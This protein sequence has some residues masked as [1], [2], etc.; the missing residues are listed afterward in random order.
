MLTLIDI[1]KNGLLTK[2]DIGSLVA[3]SG[4]VPRAVRVSTNAAR[5]ALT[6]AQVKNLDWVLVAEWVN[7]EHPV[8][9]VVDENNLDS[10][11]G[12][13]HLGSFIS[14]PVNLTAPTISG[15][16]AKNATLTCAHGSWSDSP[17]SYTYQWQSSPTPFTTWTNILLATSATYRASAEDVDSKLRCLVCAVNVL[18]TST[19]TA[20]AATAVVAET[21][22][23]AAPDVTG[24]TAYFY[25]DP[26]LMTLDENGLIQNLTTVDTL[27]AVQPS[28]AVN[29]PA[30]DAVNGEIV[31]VKADGTNLQ[32][33][34]FDT[35]PDDYTV[36]L[37]GKNGAAVDYSSVIQ[38][39]QRSLW[40]ERLEGHVD[41]GY[42]DYDNFLD[43]IDCRYLEADLSLVIGGFDCTNGKAKVVRDLESQ[44][45]TGISW[46]ASSV[47][48]DSLLLGA[49]YVA[50]NANYRM[51]AC[52]IFDHYLSPTEIAE[53]RSW[54]NSVFAIDC[55]PEA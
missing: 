39:G 38:V 31:F 15:L 27:K 22:I 45:L 41:L 11:V 18:G 43:Q 47:N 25:A 4:S 26:S 21:A 37:I 17:T 52:L 48:P 32:N 3:A 23:P 12:Y 5:F 30:F 53:V 7:N 46:P 2:E 33:A 35:F 14:V 40:L 55:I 34:T 29:A 54:A 20:S 1:I 28:A 36:V 44:E 9:G 49:Y 19:A 50:Y 51:K 42:P 16:A 8:Y 24:C 10:E 13:V 6:K